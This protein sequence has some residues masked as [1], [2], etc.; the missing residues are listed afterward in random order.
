M[1]PQTTARDR[2]GD[3]SYWDRALYPFPL[4]LSWRR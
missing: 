1:N 3:P 2:S 4:P